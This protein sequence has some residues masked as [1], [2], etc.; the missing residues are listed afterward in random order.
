MSANDEILFVL[1]FDRF[2]YLDSGFV[3]FGCNGCGSDAVPFFFFLFLV[4]VCDL[5]GSMDDFMGWLV[6][7][8]GF[9]VM[10]SAAGAV[11]G[12]VVFD[13]DDHG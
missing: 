13:R 4:V 1:F 3:V 5:G 8:I 10:D 9:R 2:L 6:C 11:D 12:F 7:W